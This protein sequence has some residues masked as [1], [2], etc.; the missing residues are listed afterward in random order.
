MSDPASPVRPLG[1]D[2]PE[3][4]VQAG[5]LRFGSWRGIPGT[6]NLIDHKRPYH[7]AL[8]RRIR[9]FRLK[10]WQAIQAGDESVFLFAV[11]YNAKFLSMINVEVWD[12]K[13]KT[14]YRWRH[15]EPGSRFRLPESLYA[16]SGS[17]RTTVKTLHGR[18]ALSVDA[19]GGEV[20]FDA[21]Y[22]SPKSALLSCSL[23]FTLDG[24]Y[25][26]PFSV[27]LPFDLNRGM[28][29][30]KVLMPV[31]GEL[32][33]GSNVLSLDPA[34]ACGILDD[35]KGYYPYR[36]HYDWVTGFGVDKTGR[37]IGFNLT[38]NQAREPE[39]NNENRLW[40][41]NT[42]HDLPV[43]RIT[44]PHGRAEPWIIQDTEGMVDLVFV[45]ETENEIRVRAGVAEIDYAGPF[46]HF[47]GT[48][49]SPDGESIDAS[50][51]YGMGEDKTMRL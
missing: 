47:Q 44:R 43:V 40:M 22:L 3:A 41:G 36:L 17:T 51:L 21:H 50:L 2:A 16:D 8:P 25:C 11:L 38:C 1:G 20:T 26:A 24:R 13:A 33:L 28:Y 32:L 18:C 35:H 4:L 30:T 5:E 45:P 27:S 12:R 6:A 23:D 31:R 15:I 42:V 46:G 37:R 9:D 34:T 29:S 49:K 14:R 19:A 48:L 39:R 7:L 10:E